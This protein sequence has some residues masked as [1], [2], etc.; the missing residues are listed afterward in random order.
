MNERYKFMSEETNII[1]QVTSNDYKYGF[2]TN[3]ENEYAPKGLNEDIVR[4][5]SMKKN[6]PEF[7]LNWRLKAYNFWLKMKGTC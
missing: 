4:F 5:I 2:V 1:E 3:V 6:E 7:M